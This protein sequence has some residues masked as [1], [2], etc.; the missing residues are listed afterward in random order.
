MSKNIQPASSRS[1]KADDLAAIVH[2]VFAG[3]HFVELCKLYICTQVKRPLHRVDDLG[4][5]SS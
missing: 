1:K 3:L 2:T 4:A 5:R